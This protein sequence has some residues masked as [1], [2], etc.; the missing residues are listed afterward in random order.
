MNITT[1]TND[2]LSFRCFAS[3]RWVLTSSSRGNPNLANAVLTGTATYGGIEIGFR[4]VPQTVSNANYTFV[5]ADKGQCRL[6]NNTSA[7]TYT[8][9]PSVF[10]AGDVL[11]VFNTGTAGNISIA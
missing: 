8:V 5:L 7:V 2:L 11:T 4:G 3:G 9:P 1:A 10:A 6:K